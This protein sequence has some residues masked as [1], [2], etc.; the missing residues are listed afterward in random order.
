MGGLGTVPLG[1]G[2]HDLVATAD[3]LHQAAGE[4]D[5]QDL[6]KKKVWESLLPP[7]PPLPSPPFMHMEGFSSAPY[8]KEGNTQRN[9]GHDEDVLLHPHFNTLLAALVEGGE[10]EKGGGS[11]SHSTGG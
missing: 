11:A 6:G 8:L 2:L 9:S 4:D 7:P 10:A 5:A 3:A 1:G